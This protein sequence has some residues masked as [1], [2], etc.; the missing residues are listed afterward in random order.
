MSIIQLIKFVA[1]ALIADRATISTL[2]QKLAD[3][4]LA[5]SK[6]A[7]VADQKAAEMDK[8][9][10]QHLSDIAA[11]LTT[12]LADDAA[13]EA[14]LTDISEQLQSIQ[15]KY[16][17]S[18]AVILELEGKAKSAQA[19]ADMAKADA[20]EKAKALADLDAEND[21]AVKLLAD[22]LGVDPE[23]GEAIKQPVADTEQ[24][25]VAV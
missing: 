12:A 1:I 8:E 23:T 20:D 17:D 21:D 15:S 9:Y 22:A 5:A 2:T 18:Q 16:T 11:E 6:A 3:Q 24:V 7:Q 10:Q 13:D 14:K 19:E 25:A 4:D